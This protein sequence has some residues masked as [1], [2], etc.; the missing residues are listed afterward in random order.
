MVQHGL[1]KWW[2]LA[3]VMEGWEGEVMGWVTP[4]V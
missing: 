4:L 1:V 3:G 2:A